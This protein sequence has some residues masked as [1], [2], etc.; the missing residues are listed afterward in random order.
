MPRG[1]RAAHARCA[2]RLAVVLLLAVLLWSEPDVVEGHHANTSSNN[3]AHSPD[4]KLHPWS[5]STSSICDGNRGEVEGSRSLQQAVSPFSSWSSSPELRLLKLRRAPE[6]FFSQGGV[7]PSGRW[8]VSYAPRW[9]FLVERRPFGVVYSTYSSRPK[10]QKGGS[11]APTRR[12]TSRRRRCCG[13]PCA[14]SG[15]VPGGIWIGSALVSW[16]RIELRFQFVIWVFSVICR[17]LFVVLR[18]CCVLVW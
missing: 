4:L 10:S 16:I 12:P 2:G 5:V 15:F 9:Y 8:P 1:V 17:D 3:L 6:R 11:S 13:D 14:P 7:R 18:L